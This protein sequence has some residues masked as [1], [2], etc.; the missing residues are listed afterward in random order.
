MLAVGLT[1][2]V[3]TMPQSRPP[4]IDRDLVLSRNWIVLPNSS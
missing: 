1:L 4:G 3:L 2:L